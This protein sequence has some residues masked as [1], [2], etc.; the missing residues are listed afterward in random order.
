VPDNE[1]EKAIKY[2]NDFVN[3]FNKDNVKGA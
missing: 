1:I 3:R 2:K